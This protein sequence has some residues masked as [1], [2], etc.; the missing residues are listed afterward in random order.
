MRTILKTLI[1]TAIM[2]V[3]SQ[4]DV[5]VKGYYKKSGTYVAPYVRSNPDKNPYNNYYSKPQKYKYG[6]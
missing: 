4:A 3:A 5:Y 6:Y 2:M 1:I